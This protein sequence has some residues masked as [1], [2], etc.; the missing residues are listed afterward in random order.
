MYAN[1]SRIFGVLPELSTRETCGLLLIPETISII[2]HGFTGVLA[3]GTEMHP[4]GVSPHLR[5]HDAKGSTRDQ[6]VGIPE[7]KNGRDDDHRPDRR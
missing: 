2:K 1:Y 4:T 3:V 7:N 5:G 6:C